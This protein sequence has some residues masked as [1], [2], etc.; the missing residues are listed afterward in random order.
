MSVAVVAVHYPRPEHHDELV[1]RVCR[2]AEVMQSVTGCI[3]AD[4]WQD[5]ATGAIVTTGVWRSDEAR[6]ASFEAVKVAHVDID[7]DDREIRARD[8]FMLSSLRP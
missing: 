2:A 7:H 8:V 3:A 4:C 1:A 5:D 6:A